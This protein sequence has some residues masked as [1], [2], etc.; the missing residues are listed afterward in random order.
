M[1]K[2]GMYAVHLVAFVNQRVATPH[3][4]ALPVPKSRQVCQLFNFGMIAT[5]NHHFE[6]FAALCNTLGG[7]QGVRDL[8]F[9]HSTNSPV[10]SA[11]GGFYPPPTVAAAEPPT[12][13][14]LVALPADGTE[15]LGEWNQLPQLPLG[16]PRGEAV[17]RRLTDEGWR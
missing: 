3:Q 15:R 7:S 9:Y 5:G 17:S 10:P 12:G 14:L 8:R 13:R 2:T 6:R 1:V 4:S 11:S 16:F